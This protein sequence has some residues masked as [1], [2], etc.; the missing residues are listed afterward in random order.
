MVVSVQ[1]CDGVYG[2]IER[3]NEQ[4]GEGAGSA[5]FAEISRGRVSLQHPQLLDV[6]RV[7]KGSAHGSQALLPEAMPRESNDLR[8]DALCRCAPGG[9]TGLDRAASNESEEPATSIDQG[10]GPQECGDDE[11]RRQQHR[12]CV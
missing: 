12:L 7:A 10:D 6:A 5:K 8:M 9:I 3:M 2:F 4:G 1:P 11:S